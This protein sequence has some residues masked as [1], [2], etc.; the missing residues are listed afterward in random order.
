MNPPFVAGPI[1]SHYGLKNWDAV[2]FE[3]RVVLVPMPLWSTIKIGAFAGLS[4]QLARREA[5]K[6]TALTQAKVQEYRTGPPAPGAVVLSLDTVQR[7]GIKRIALTASELRLKTAAK[8][9]V[10]GILDVTALDGYEAA[11]QRAYPDR[12]SGQWR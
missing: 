3:D 9:W 1:F 5:Q 4:A 7:L 12:Y 6:Q 8:E 2:F 11:L 10:F